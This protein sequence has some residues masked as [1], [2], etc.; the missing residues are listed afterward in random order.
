MGAANKLDGMVPLW[1]MLPISGTPVEKAG[2]ALSDENLC[3]SLY[4]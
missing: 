1:R 2:G 4:R 3:Q